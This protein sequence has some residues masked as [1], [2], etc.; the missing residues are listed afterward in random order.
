MDETMPAAWIVRRYAEL[1]GE[2]VA[3]G[4]DAH[5]PEHIGH[6]FTPIAQMLEDNG[7]RHLAVFRDRECIMEPL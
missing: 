5:Q 3:L 2:A 1:G 4:S 7:I 6:A